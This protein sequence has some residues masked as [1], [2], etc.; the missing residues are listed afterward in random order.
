MHG[1]LTLW[2]YDGSSKELHVSHNFLCET[3]PKNVYAQTETVNNKQH[4]G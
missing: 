2:V 3:I 1:W 4:V